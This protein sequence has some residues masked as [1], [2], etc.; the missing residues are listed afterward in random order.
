MWNKKLDCSDFDE[1]T[2][3]LSGKC[4]TFSLALDNIEE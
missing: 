2:Q 4:S 1:N 3:A